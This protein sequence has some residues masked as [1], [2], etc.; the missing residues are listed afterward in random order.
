[1]C[2][3]AAGC[4]SPRITA[5][6][7][8]CEPQSCAPTYLG[9][10]PR[11]LRSL[12]H[13]VCFLKK[14]YIPHLPKITLFLIGCLFFFEGCGGIQCLGKP[15]DGSFRSER[16]AWNPDDWDQWGQLGQHLW[17]LETGLCPFCF[18]PCLQVS[19][20]ENILMS[21]SACSLGTLLWTNSVDII[22]LSKLSAG[23][24]S[25][26]NAGDVSSIPGS[27]RSPGE[28]NGNPLQ[29]SCPGN[30][31]DREAWWA[32]VHRVAKS[33]IGVSTHAQQFF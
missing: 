5:A 33:Q 21:P 26:F 16:K 32:T 2:G 3:V 19:Q 14:G 6:L 23:K 7:P 24:E 9:V 15:L 27:G 30:P 12:D 1:M 18:S 20:L 13:T 8:D 28:G 29:Y 31:M 11:S 4:K 25:T 10:S 17:A 22:W